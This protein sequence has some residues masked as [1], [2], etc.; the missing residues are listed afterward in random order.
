MA[1][2]DSDGT[3]PG[4]SVTPYGDQTFPKS[5]ISSFTIFAFPS[6]GYKISHIEISV[7]G[8]TWS[9]SF[10]DYLINGNQITIYTTEQDNT[11]YYSVVFAPLEFTTTI[12]TVMPN[13]PSWTGAS[14]QIDITVSSGTESWSGNIATISKVTYNSNLKISLDTETSGNPYILKHVTINGVVYT[15]VDIGNRVYE[16]TVSSVTSDLDIKITLASTV[17]LTFDYSDENFSSSVNNHFNLYD[18]DGKNPQVVTSSN[19]E[20]YIEKG[21]SRKFSVSIDGEMEGFCIYKLRIDDIPMPVQPLYETWQMNGDT[22]V[23]IELKKVDNWVTINYRDDGSY[24]IGF[25]IQTQIVL[26]TQATLETMGYMN[27]G[28]NLLGW[29][30]VENGFKVYDPDTQ[31]SVTVTENTEFWAVWTLAQY[32]ITYDMNGGDLSAPAGN[33][34]VFDI[35]D[36][37]FSLVLP[38]RTGYGPGHWEIDGT[39]IS[40]IDPQTYPRDLVLT[41]VWGTPITYTVTLIDESSGVTDVIGTLNI[42]YGSKYGSLPMLSGDASNSFSGWSLDEGGSDRVTGSTIMKKGENHNLYAVWAPN[43]HWIIELTGFNT[44][45]G[46]ISVPTSVANGNEALVVIT[47]NTGYKIDGIILSGSGEYRLDNGTWITFNGTNITVS[48]GGSQSQTSFWIKPSGDIILEAVMS[49]VEYTITVGCNFSDKDPI[50]AHIYTLTYTIEDDI[51]II[52]VPTTAHANSIFIGWSGTGINGVSDA[53]IIGTGSTGNRTYTANWQSI[54]LPINYDLLGGGP[55]PTRSVNTSRGERLL[56]LRFPPRLGTP[57]RDGSPTRDT[58]PT[59]YSRR[60]T[61]RIRCTSMR[62]SK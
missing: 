20:F 36:E 44:K 13:N 3:S 18:K 28:Y 30:K 7:N 61:R 4:G 54:V 11:K 19:N 37:V 24:R 40:A 12:D 2:R 35:N 41:A 58:P 23:T 42:E 33:P 52:P 21:T 27:P 22:A 57:S 55:Y 26:P 51:I 1:S 29:A 10:T 47:P 25:Y 38:G 49:L 59:R 48:L 32:S 17:K 9:D 15:P 43:G 8:T 39:E 45:T 46:S 60:S 5:G 34:D 53:L 6:T 56:R 14:N 50:E 31:I 62:S 16:V